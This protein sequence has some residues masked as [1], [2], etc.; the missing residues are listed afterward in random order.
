MNHN[1]SRDV[2][3]LCEANHNRRKWAE[4]VE[5]KNCPGGRG[6]EI[7]TSGH[8]APPRNDKYR[9][10]VKTAVLACAMAAGGGAAFAGMGIAMS[11]GA[12]VFVGVLI[13]VIF[14]ASGLKLEGLTN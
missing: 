7:A 8:D 11:H 6:V 14:G 2:E 12:T 13:A 1:F 5:E 9:G 3:W 10:A 4:E